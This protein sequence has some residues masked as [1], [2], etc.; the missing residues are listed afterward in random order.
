[1]ARHSSRLTWSGWISI[2]TKGSSAIA[3]ECSRP[4]QTSCSSGLPVKCSRDNTM[5][6]LEQLSVDIMRLKKS[7]P[8]HQ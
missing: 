4:E 2:E 7:V 6:N 3:A 8:A 1:M 5:G